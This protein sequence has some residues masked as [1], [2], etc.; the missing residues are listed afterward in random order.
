VGKE[1]H[2]ELDVLGV[3]KPYLAQIIWQRYHPLRVG[4]ELVK[5]AGQL[6][7]LA[8]DLPDQ[9]NEILEDTR[10]G[11]LQIRAV[12]PESA[13]ATERLGR[14]VRA[15]VLCAALLGSGV[16]LLVARVQPTLAWALI[17][18]AGLWLVGH[19]FQDWRTR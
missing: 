4:E 14:R 2:P 6:A 10:Q 15:A 17:A 19:L 16:A 5:N 8:R 3:A 13:R 1:I 9:L 11:R 7:S 12:D 18:A